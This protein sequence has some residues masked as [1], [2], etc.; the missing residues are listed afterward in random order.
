[1]SQR[2]Y[3]TVQNPKLL[4]DQLNR[5]V[6]ATNSDMAALNSTIGTH[7][8]QLATLQALLADALARFTVLEKTNG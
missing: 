2:H 8:S 4:H 7:T 1:M 3:D 6:D 5:N